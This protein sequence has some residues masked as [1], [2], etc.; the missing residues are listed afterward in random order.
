MSNQS[1]VGSQHHIVPVSTY[2]FTWIA[3]IILMLLTIG[4][5]MVTL[6]TLGNNL[7]AIGIAV[8]KALLVITIF[9]G[10]KYA[11]SLIRIWATFGFIWVLFLSG[12]LLD[13]S[14]QHPVQGFLH[15][16]SSSMPYHG[17]NM[18]SDA[19]EKALES[20]ATQTNPSNGP[21]PVSSASAPT[22]S[23]P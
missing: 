20:Q 2:V 17:Q 19:Q 16:V 11:S 7:V 3:L 14:N 9:M 15:D 13:F 4:A 18:I 10:V 23:N 1:P 6:G 22:P 12:I 21:L 5:S 8:I